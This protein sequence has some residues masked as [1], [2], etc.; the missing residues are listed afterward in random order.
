VTDPEPGLF[1]ISADDLLRLF[2]A[3]P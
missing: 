2:D 1:T 3:G